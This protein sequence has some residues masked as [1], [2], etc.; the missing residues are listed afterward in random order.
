MPDLDISTDQVDTKAA[1]PSDGPGVESSKTD[2]F[3][4][5][6]LPASGANPRNTTSLSVQAMPPYMGHQSEF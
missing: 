3:A 4:S 1:E 5:D 2:P 6:R